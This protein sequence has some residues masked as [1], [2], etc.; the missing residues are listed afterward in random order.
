MFCRPSADAV[1]EQQPGEGVTAVAAFLFSFYACYIQYMTRQFT[2]IGGLGAIGFAATIVVANLLVVPAGF[3]TPGADVAEAA[4]FL[5]DHGGLV[6][7]SSALTPIAWFCI[8][9]FAAGA[10]AVLW[11]QERRRNEAW[12]VVGAAGLLLQT[13]VF[14]GVIAVRL[15]LVQQ[16]DQAAA[17]WP[18]QDALL[19]INGTFLALALTGLSVAGLRC[20]LIRRWHYTVGLIAATLTFGSAILTP[21][22]IDR[23]GP[24][25]LIGLAG[26][27]LWVVWLVAYG[28]ALWR[29][30][31]RRVGAAVLHEGVQE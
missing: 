29:L 24:L 22:V 27:L 4:A 16:P 17:L 23:S 1:G 18:L 31:S 8:V 7:L 28:I 5:A 26:W 21:L 10:F 19:T 3:P 15:A 25:G 6:D 11:P 2:R 13:A 14:V 12:S 30:G 9:L 20:G